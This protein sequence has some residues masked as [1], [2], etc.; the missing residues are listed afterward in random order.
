MTGQMSIF[1][2]LPRQDDP[3]RNAIKRMR[4]YWTSSR[5]RIIDAYYSGNNFVETVK[6]EYSPY[7][8]AGHYGGDFGKKGVFTLT[9]WELKANRIT[10]QYDPYRIETITWA[11][12]AEHIADLIRTKEFLKG[13]D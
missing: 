1:D 13:D 7:G 5:Q 9:G 3:I 12:F 4:P 2:F 6:R 11:D 8:H 10:F